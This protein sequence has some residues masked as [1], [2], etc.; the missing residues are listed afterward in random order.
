MSPCFPPLRALST[1][2]VSLALDSHHSHGVTFGRAEHS[3]GAP[4]HSP[5]A[6]C[7][8]CGQASC[9]NPWIQLTVS[10]DCGVLLEQLRRAVSTYRAE[11]GVCEPG[12]GLSQQCRQAQWAHGPAP[13]GA[14]SLVVLYTARGLLWDVS[15]QGVVSGEFRGEHRGGSSALEAPCAGGRALCSSLSCSAG[16]QGLTKVLG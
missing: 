9:T 5:A 8:P 7:L 13:L 15:V 4:L 3:P 6:R 1:R 2:P 12:L 11:Q 14:R 16:Q 10:H